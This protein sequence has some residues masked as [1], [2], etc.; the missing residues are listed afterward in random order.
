[1]WALRGFFLIGIALGLARLAFIGALAFA[2]WRRSRKRAGAAE[3]GSAGESPFVSII[4]P[5]YNEEK[6]IAQTITSLLGS[7]YPRF[8]IIVVDD[9]S[10]DR[11]SDVMRDQFSGDPRVRLFTKANGGKAEALNFG[12]RYARGEIIV[13]LDADTIF[14]PRTL[15]ALARR[16]D[17]PLVGAIAGNAK[18]GNRIN[19]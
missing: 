9:G 8:E 19:L 12:L 4:I 6:V 1:G 7:T 10:P 16:F 15:G 2:Q 14:P 3:S 5:A 11:T 13:A 17:D 18:V